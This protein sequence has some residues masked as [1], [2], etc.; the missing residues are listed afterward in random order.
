MPAATPP[1]AP[2]AQSDEIPSTSCTEGEEAALVRESQAG[3][4]GVWKVAVVAAVTGLIAAA[5]TWWSKSGNM[6]A[7]GDEVTGLATGGAMYGTIGCSNWA[8]IEISRSQV[9]DQ[10]ECAT[11]CI[12]T[13]E[14]TMYNWQQNA[15]EPGWPV[16]NGCLLF[17]GSCST[18]RN[19]CWQLNYKLE[20][21]ETVVTQTVTM[22]TS[23][24]KEEA[25]KAVK[26]AVEAQG[27]APVEATAT[28]QRRLVGEGR[29]LQ[30]IN[31]WSVTWTF[32]T[33]ND[34]KGSEAYTWA[35]SVTT[36]KAAEVAFVAGIKTNLPAG[37]SLKVIDIGEP[38]KEKGGTTETP[39]SKTTM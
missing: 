31:I 27:F 37:S 16:A 15:C 2:V 17:K 5:G 34:A 26:E 35:V 14:C 21:T 10:N 13:A 23:A 1:F 33:F 11:K 9:A 7:V 24:T 6:D 3:T 20:E 18:E 28:A 8:S 12:N 32:R 29:N 30:Q 39:E 19:V 36:S 22:E 25:E 38:V 4:R